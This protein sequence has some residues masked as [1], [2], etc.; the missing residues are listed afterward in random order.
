MVTGVETAGLVL[1][2]FPLVVD[3]L[4]HYADGIQTIQYWRRYRRELR[5]YARKLKSQG[6][7]Y[8][9]TLELLFDGIVESEEELAAL[10]KDPAGSLWQGTEYEEGLRSRLD[11]SYGHFLDVLKNMIETL[12]AM[13]AR[14]GID[15]SGNVS[16]PSKSIRNGKLRMHNSD[17]VGPTFLSQARDEKA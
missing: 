15:P 4:S 3:G 14:L 9:N 2:A 6:V 7:R 13:K 8:Q 16:A 5:D 11:H 12:D 1:A 17:H 10:L